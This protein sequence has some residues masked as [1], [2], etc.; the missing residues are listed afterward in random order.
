MRFYFYVS[1]DYINQKIHLCTVRRNF[2]DWFIFILLSIIWGSSFILMKLGLK[3]LTAFQFA[4]LRIF[5]AG[6]V[7]LPSAMKYIRQIPKD[8]LSLVFLSGTLGSLIPAFLFCFAE[9][10]IDSGLA[11]TLNSLTP[12]FVIITGALFFNS[13]TTTVKII[14]I[15]IALTGSILLLLTKNTSSIGKGLGYS[16][17]IVL[18]TFLYGFN[19]NMVARKL[20]NIPSLHIAA[21]ALTLNA[22]PAFLILIFTGYFSLPLRDTKIMIAT[23]CASLLGI[24]GTA[25][26]TIIFYALVKKAGSIFASMVTYGIPVVAIGWG[27]IYKEEIGWR[28]IFCLLIILLGVYI[29]NKKPSIA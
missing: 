21:V 1:V 13:K 14:G 26:S 29:T 10:E 28:Q 16:S 11:G 27:I 7:L 4:A 20:H 17:F 6:I 12:I 5:F 18:A 19:V 15:L 22:I 25:I 24:L 3:D 2:N 9:E 8:K 23:G